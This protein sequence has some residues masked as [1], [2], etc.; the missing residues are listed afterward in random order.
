VRD[1]VLHHRHNLVVTS[2]LERDRRVSAAAL[3]HRKPSF[4]M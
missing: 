2:A 4:F 1:R 3:H